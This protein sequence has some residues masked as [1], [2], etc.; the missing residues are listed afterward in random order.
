ML[1]NLVSVYFSTARVSSVTSLVIDNF[2]G[3]FYIATV[4]SSVK[5]GSSVK[6]PAGSVA[7]GSVSSSAE[8]G[9]SRILAA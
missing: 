5:K 7:A 6:K 3:M 2:F 4:S 1:R 8:A 9:P